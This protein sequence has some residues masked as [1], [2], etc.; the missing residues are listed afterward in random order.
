MGASQAVTKIALIIL[1]HGCSFVCFGHLF[2]NSVRASLRYVP[3]RHAS[4]RSLCWARL[5]VA[6]GFRPVTLFA[7]ALYL[8]S[9]NPGSS[10]RSF[11]T[12][13]LLPVF[14]H[15]G[16]A[17]KRA[18]FG[19]LHSTSRTGIPPSG[20][21]RFRNFAFLAR[22][23]LPAVTF[24]CSCYYIAVRNLHC[25]RCGSISWPT[26]RYDDLKRHPCFSRPQAKSAPGLRLP[27]VAIHRP[28]GFL[29]GTGG[30]TR[31][32]LALRSFASVQPVRSS[33]I[34]PFAPPLAQ[35]CFSL[36]AVSSICRLLTSKKKA[37]VF[38]SEVN[39]Y[40]NRFGQVNPT[41]PPH[42]RLYEF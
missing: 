8:Q 20:S 32:R 28:S 5:R 17:R 15:F 36:P 3:S 29:S 39:T 9:L 2:H 37:E 16:T 7:K 30:S 1:P 19:P 22:S 6:P 14:N 25:S 4:N 33:L 24:R 21:M 38:V 41:V 10:L 34:A 42:A 11:L 27:A 12:H 35:G 23:I 31:S 18:C 26:G 40:I 13:W